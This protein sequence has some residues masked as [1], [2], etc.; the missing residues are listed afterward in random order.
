MADVDNAGTPQE[1]GRGLEQLS[2]PE[3]RFNP[4]SERG[5]GEDVE[6][7]GVNPG[8]LPPKDQTSSESG[9]KEN[10]EARN[11]EK[12]TE[13]EKKLTEP[14]P[15][16]SAAKA[17]YDWYQTQGDVVINIM[18]K[19]LRTEDVSVHFTEKAVRAFRSQDGQVITHAPAWHNSICI[20]FYA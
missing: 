1:A 8:S 9:S 20:L 3:K 19:K 18:I 7:D 13:T 2:T 15:M 12:A 4:P 11:S 10:G 17:K 14:L 16:P 6:K 5:T